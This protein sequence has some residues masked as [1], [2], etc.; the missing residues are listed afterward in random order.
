MCVE[1]GGRHFVLASP[2]LQ[3]SVCSNWDVLKLVHTSS[4]Y[5]FV[6]D[7]D[8]NEEQLRFNFASTVQ[9]FN[10]L[11]IIPNFLA[12]VAFQFSTPKT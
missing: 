2:E 12:E 1:I 5:G 4:Y 6:K 9:P 10:D 8:I 7:F 3:P 11:A